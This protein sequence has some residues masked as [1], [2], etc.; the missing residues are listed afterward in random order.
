MKNKGAFLPICLFLILR[1]VALVPVA[2]A[3]T[4]YFNTTAVGTTTFQG[5]NTGGYLF[6]QYN[7]GMAPLTISS[8]T[9]Y[10]TFFSPIGNDCTNPPTPGRVNILTY[11]TG[12][13]PEIGSYS[14]TV[15]TGF[16]SPTFIGVVT[17]TG[18]CYLTYAFDGV[19]WAK[20]SWNLNNWVVVETGGTD[21]AVDP[22][23]PIS[24]PYN[25]GAR[26]G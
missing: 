17:T 9:V 14:D 2:Q 6:W 26:D 19:N 10:L 4:V 5:T 1:L 18:G 16:S 22:F 15:V 11:G 12:P 8:Q 21:L 3:T 20:P 25:G 7:V 24:A 23:A 13:Q